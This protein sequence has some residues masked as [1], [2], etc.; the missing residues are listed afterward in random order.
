MSYLIL[1]AIGDDRPGL[2]EEL[3]TAISAHGG[4]WL[5]SS[6][7][8]L[9]GKFAGIVKVAIP[10]SGVEPLKTPWPSSP[11][12]GQRRSRRSRKVGAAGRRD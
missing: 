12:S 6:M 4:N 10:A 11:D 1:T 3:A 8:H 5:E 2:V 7:A 9:S